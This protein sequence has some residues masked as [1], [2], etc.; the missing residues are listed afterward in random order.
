[1]ATGD[2]S[3]G[4]GAWRIRAISIPTLVLLL[5]AAPV[6]AQEVP[7]WE[8][9]QGHGMVGHN[10][11]VPEVLTPG[12]C[13]AKCDA[14]AGCLGFDYYRNSSQCLLNDADGRAAPTALKPNGPV[15]F[16]QR[17]MAD[18]HGNP[19]PPFDP[20]RPDW[21]VSDAYCR[22]YAKTAVGQNAYNINHQCGYRGRRWTS[23]FD[24]HFRWCKFSPPSN[25]KFETSQRRDALAACQARGGGPAG[26][27]GTGVTGSPGSGGA[28]RGPDSANGTGGLADGGGFDQ[29]WTSHVGRTCFQ[30]WVHDTEARL[31]NNHGSD[32]Y[33]RDKPFQINIYG[34]ISFRG[35]GSVFAPDDWNAPDINRNRFAYL[36]KHM[37]YEGQYW[38][39]RHQA[40]DPRDRV[41]LHGL[42][43]YVKHCMRS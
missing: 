17:A 31:N 21:R 18:T 36:W 25:S 1:M 5:L 2:F 35:A 13:A 32:K 3:T 16:Y 7:G 41:Q 10:M 27:S 43:W 26:G 11:G 12:Q 15:D 33:N 19:A 37:T 6:S 23:D 34:L 39:F 20:G 28:G 4:S 9:I 42:R 30:R 38:Y 22:D 8:R 29:P 40:P 24:G 14:T